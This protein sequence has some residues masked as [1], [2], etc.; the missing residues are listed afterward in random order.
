MDI[1]KT[2]ILIVVFKVLDLMSAPY[3]S[4]EIIDNKWTEEDDYLMAYIENDNLTGD[5]MEKILD[6]MYMDYASLMEDIDPTV[7]NILTEALA[8]AEI[9]EIYVLN[10]WGTEHMSLALNHM[11]STVI[12]SSNKPNV[13]MLREFIRLNSI[14]GTI[15]CMDLG[16]VIMQW[17]INGK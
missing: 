8:G 13:K 1:R 2:I 5:K 7:E 6:D 3:L 16:T 9:K 15:S 12:Y 10:R 14:N 11:E 4:A 17:M